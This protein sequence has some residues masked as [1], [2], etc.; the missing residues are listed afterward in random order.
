MNIGITCY[1]TYGGSGVIATELGLELAKAGHN[2]HFISYRLPFRLSR[3]NRN[4]SFHEVDIFDYPLFKYPPYSLSLSAKM[5]EVAESENLDILHVHYAMPHATSAYLAKKMLGERRIKSV[6]TLHGTDITLVG[7]HSSFYKIT[8]FSIEE[9]DGITCVS[10]Y[11]R[12]TTRKTFKVNKEMKVIYNFIDTKRYKR[13]VKK[14]KKLDFVGKDDKVIIHISNFRP[15]KNIDHIIKVFNLVS[16]EIKSKLLLVGDGP[17]IYRM[18]NIV[19]RLKLED[20]VLFLGIQ[21]NII[22]LLNMS[23]LYMLPSK[24]EGFGLSALEALSCEVPV[25]GTDVGGLKEVVEH[26]KSGFI[27]DPEDIDSMTKAAVKILSD[28]DIR[29]KM[30]REARKRSELFDVNIIVPQYIDYYNTVL[31]I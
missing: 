31:N 19:S 4:I 6:T 18:R 10:N 30:G 11:L 12:D 13:T 25:I 22:P 28:N 27:F 23:D 8:K 5:A 3:F 9:S 26:G 29:L 14:N 16:R 20:K 7:T 1:P 17:D 15:L 21:E 24:S 2:I